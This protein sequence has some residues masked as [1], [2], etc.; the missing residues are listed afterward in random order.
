MIG[1]EA[2]G[3]GGDKAVASA[4]SDGGIVSRPAAPTPTLPTKKLGM[5]ELLVTC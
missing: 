2:I 5:L 4:G 1:D 3:V